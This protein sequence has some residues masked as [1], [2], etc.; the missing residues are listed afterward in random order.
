MAYFL[1]RTVRSL[2]HLSSPQIVQVLLNESGK[3]EVTKSLLSLLYNICIDKSVVLSARLKRRF[4]GYD[5]LVR[6]LLKGVHVKTNRT[7]QVSEKRA[8]LLRNPEFVRLLSLACPVK[9]DE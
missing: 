6:K 9:L 5:S 3:L 1:L 2:R 4:P 7:E 8:L